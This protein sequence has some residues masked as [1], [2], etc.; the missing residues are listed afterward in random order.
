MKTYIGNNTFVELL[1]FVKSH[2]EHVESKVVQIHQEGGDDPFVVG[3]L[4]DIIRKYRLWV[5]TLPRV[6]PF[7]AVK[8][9][10]DFVVLKLLADLGASFDCA[11]K[12]EIQKILNQGVSTSRII[13]AN[14]C[15]QAS[16]LR[17]AAKHNVPLMT[18]DNEAELYKVKDIYPSAK[19][20]IRM[21]PPTN[22]KVQCELGMKFGCLPSQAE[23]LLVIAKSLG[24]DVVGVSFH[25][26][27]GCEEANAFGIAIQQARD[28]FDKGLQLGF[29]MT[30]LDIGGGFP[31]QESAPVSFGEI[32]QV[33]NMALD[34]YFHEEDIQIIAEPGR[35]F[36]A[37]AFTIGVN[38]IAKRVVSRDR[39][40][41][42][43]EPLE[44]SSSSDEP[45][46]MYYVND[47]V[48]GSFNCLL[49]DHAT[50]SPSILKNSED[51]MVYSSSVWGPTCDGLDCILENTQLPDL[52]VGEWMYFKDMGAYTMAS[53]ST[54]NGMPAPTRSYHCLDT[55]WHEVYPDT[56]HK[57][58]S[59]I[60][61]IPKMKAGHALSDT[62][63]VFEEMM[64][65]SP[66]EGFVL[67]IEH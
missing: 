60:R 41:E 25:V 3:D 17:Y 18:F 20:V 29:D 4:G 13:Y 49:Y 38:V 24:L 64:A 37:S 12:G 9:N 15:K 22:F 54:F 16:F 45:S 8:C 6:K 35:Y 43:G 21:L 48:Y 5:H 14:P 50:V 61:D 19:L 65:S 1:P 26:G 62:H 40:G 59:R 57:P 7:Y 53:A 58:C 51:E 2:S 67:D 63:T 56:T 30:L 39:T 31:G 47:G 46:V 11:S 42:N 34:K 27:S 44:H 28:V 55:I 10:D 66:V 23:K 52:D 33:V 36:V 32:A